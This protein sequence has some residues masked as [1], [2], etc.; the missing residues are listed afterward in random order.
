MPNID[1]A[2]YLNGYYH[3][4]EAGLKLAAGFIVDYKCN[5]KTITADDLK[6]IIDKLL[7]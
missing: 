3:G 1:Q 7:Q 6:K 5:K 2:N 4:F